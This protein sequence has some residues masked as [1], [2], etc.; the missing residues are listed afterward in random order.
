[1]RLSAWRV[2]TY[3]LPLAAYALAI[4]GLSAMSRLPFALP[5]WPH[6][7]KVLHA[8]EY[9]GFGVLVCR[10]LAM[11]GRGL[12]TASATVWAAV[13]GGLYGASDEVHQLFVAGRSA[14]PLD[15]IV[16]LA[17]ASLGSL[18]YRVLFLSRRARGATG[19]RDSG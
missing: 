18:A 4:Y 5:T 7:D 11:G 13:L 2:A 14:D 17:G 19:G 8:V 12:S 6:F 16:D 1:M 9:A 10:A 3:W 15:A